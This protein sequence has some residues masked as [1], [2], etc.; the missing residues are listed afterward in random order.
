MGVVAVSLRH[1]MMLSIAVELTL[2][3]DY[4]LTGWGREVLY[5]SAWVDLLIRVATDTIGLLLKAQPITP[6]HYTSMVHPSTRLEVIME[7]LSAL[8][9]GA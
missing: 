1:S 3:R 8:L 2:T 4:G 6:M 9:C 7:N 5:G